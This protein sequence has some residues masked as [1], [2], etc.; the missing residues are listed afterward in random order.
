MQ[1]LRGQRVWTLWLQERPE[2]KPVFRGRQASLTEAHRFFE[3]VCRWVREGVY[4]AKRGTLFLYGPERDC[5]AQFDIETQQVQWNAPS[6]AVTRI[7]RE[8]ETDGG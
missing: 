3:A 8:P 4:P 1:T 5:L 7:E 6:T 2:R